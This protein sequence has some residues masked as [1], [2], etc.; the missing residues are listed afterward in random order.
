M[1]NTFLLIVAFT[2]FT[3]R[4]SAQCNVVINNPA[5][6]CYPSTVDLTAAAITAGS[7]G[8]LTFTYWTDAGATSAYAT[9]TAATAG[10]YYIKGDNGSGCT[11]V[12]PVTVTVTTPPTA[13]I[14]Y[15]GTPFCR[16]IN[17]PQQVTLSGTGSYT[18]GNYSAGAGLN[19]NSN[20][21]AITPSTSTAGNYI[22]TYTI[23]AYGACPA[24]PVNTSVAIVAVPTA[25][26]VGTVT[27][28][29]CNISTGSVALSGLPASFDW[30]VTATPGG[31]TSTGNG[32]TTN[33]A[34]LVAGQ[35]YTFKV[36]N[37]AG[38]V[39]AASTG[40][41]VNAQP[42]TPTAPVV[43]LI[44]PP[45]CSLATGS[46]V[47]TGLPPTGIWTLK[48]YPGGVSTQG[49]G[50]S[51]TISGLLTGT[52]NFSVTNDANCTS[53]SL[54]NDVNILPQP[55][56][57]SAPLI[58][59]VTQP[60]CSVAT[61]SVALSGLPSDNWTVTLL[62]V[63][64]T[65]AGSGTTATFS[66]IPAGTVTFTVTGSNTCTSLPSSSVLINAA[67]ATPSAP[68]IGTVDQPTCALATG[69]IVLNSLPAGAWVL[70]RNPGGV[71]TASSGTSYTVSGLVPA[72]YSF[73]V[74]NASNCVSPSSF[75][76]AIN[77]PPAP[78]GTPEFLTD[79][80]LGFGHAVLTIT[81]PLGNNMQYSLDGGTY[82]TSTIFS[83]VANGN[84]F[85]AARNPAGCV[86]T[87]GIFTTSCGCINAPTVALSLIADST[88]GVTPVTVDG[89]TFGG[90]ATSVTI[91]ENGA[92]T[93]N[94]SSTTTSPFSFTY[95]PAA[96]DAGKKVV[97]TVTTN[98]PLGTPCLAAV[99]TFTL[100]VNAIP[101]APV[102]GTITN[103]TCSTSTGSIALSGLPST[104]TWMLTRSPDNVTA[105]GTGTTS[106]ESGI[107]AGTYT[108]IVT[109]EAGCQSSSSG[110]AVINTQP[111]SPTA[112][113][114]GA[115]THPTCTTST[116]T[117]P[118]SGLPAT[119]T[120]TLTRLPGGSTRTS[121]GA[122]YLATTIPSGTYTFTVTNAAGCVSP[123]SASF[124][125]NDQPQTPVPP[126]IGSITDPSCTEPTGSVD[127]YGLP[128]T[129]KWTLTRYSPAVADTG[130]GSSTTL[131]KIPTGTY[132]YTVM[133]EAG[134]TSGASANVFIKSA[135][136]TPAAPIILP[137][138]IT[139]PTLAVPTGSVQLS[140]LPSSGAWIITRLPDMVTTSG[141][142]GTYKITGLEGGLYNFTV[143]NVVGCTSLPSTDVII[144]TPGKPDLVI[145]DP[146]AV[147]APDKVDLTADTVTV[148]S[149]TGLTFTY[150]TDIEGT[151][152]YATP[153]A[154]D[155]GTYYIKG[156][157][158]QGFFDIKPVIATVNQKPVANA[159]PDQRL[160]A[161]FSTTLEAV[162]GEGESGLWSVVSGKGV[163]VDNT[164]PTTVV[165]DLASGNNVLKW[166]VTIGVCPADSDN[167]TIEV[168][169]VTIPTLI[170]P[171]GDT[172]NEYFVILGL[173]SLGK[174]ELTIF[175][176]RGAEV[177]KNSNY[178]NKWN[179]VDYND[180]PLPNDTYFYLLTSAKGR[181]FKGYIV[182]RR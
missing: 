115:I 101:T 100:T 12:K 150:W 29:T 132:N 155:A 19:I 116:G 177:F 117:V 22:V 113:I 118:L 47:L 91:T 102:I 97:I 141:T 152:A 11:Q 72:T 151:H 38:C 110:P 76:V 28:P 65:M 120:W 24:N 134:C 127:L 32:T 154:A 31:T 52:Y 148:G 18:G 111:D 79:C 168:G 136:A 61:G 44:T 126:S 175:D 92:G 139:Q 67:P 166:R 179:G 104:G 167:V 160:S 135:P 172:K 88:C 122:T 163:F 8:G 81:T 73:T 87:T 109:S 33:F 43:G 30:T 95:T 143:T 34:G 62:P 1:R 84:H 78:P 9:P 15:A 6:V 20:T 164:D 153:A 37:Y 13:T 98:N 51:T 176:R 121:S 138:A 49:S 45:S 63:G 128:P 53:T 96:G 170:T 86:T 181:T 173:E 90:S 107:P 142:G 157:T 35:T 156:T 174:S 27:Q 159:G 64:T 137:G 182:I 178:D 114:I 85:L 59:T 83:N 105:S 55:S 112:P 124:V 7:D 10:T 144:S 48:R 42:S 50:T 133:N 99:A 162:L 36:T 77:N 171:N 69:T 147:C 66:N 16:T 41:V 3:A 125:I 40:A 4:L 180:N 82:Q 14:S 106:T 119:G 158:V 74:T 123:Q 21:G 161:D 149:T 57:P 93:V 26:V 60:S 70:T 145:N 89:N 165:N 140:G 146:P 2:L 94:P 129:G 71:T 75:S 80:S 131:S 23:P 39:S 169:D 17:N 58:G 5:A 108:F 56:T 54:S 25:P 130:R 46:V 103:L 68:S